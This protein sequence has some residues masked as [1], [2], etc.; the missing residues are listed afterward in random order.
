MKM[1]IINFK[2]FARSGKCCANCVTIIWKYL[3]MRPPFAG[4]YYA[5]CRLWKI[6][7]HIVTFALAGIL[8]VAHQDA[9]AVEIKI[10]PCDARDLIQ[11]PG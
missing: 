4:F 7:P 9:F 6:A 8:H 2:E 5:H 3:I 1:Q 10:G 11:A